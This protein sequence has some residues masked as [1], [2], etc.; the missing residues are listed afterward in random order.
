MERERSWAWLLLPTVFAII[1]GAAAY[2]TLKST[3]QRRAR[4]C[5]YLG[6]ATT[7]LATI[8]FAVEVALYAAYVPDFG[9][10]L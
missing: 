9:V 10:N 4:D 5:L 2:Y 1:G 8:V 3:D 6:M 7:V